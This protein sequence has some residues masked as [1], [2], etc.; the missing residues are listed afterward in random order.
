MA[1][2][3]RCGTQLAEGT[4]FCT[5]CGAVISN[6]KTDK[7]GEGTSEQYKD[8]RSQPSQNTAQPRIDSIN[9]QTAH[10]MP[11]NSSGAERT[12]SPP[13]KETR[14]EPLSVGAF[15]GIAFLM[16]IPIVNIIL[17]IVWACGGAKNPNTRNYARASLIM[18]VVYI[19]LSIIL[20]MLIVNYISRFGMDLLN[21]LLPLLS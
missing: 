10:N 6:V 21:G 3:T 1:F 2:C 4:K 8:V 19:I 16:M 11:P 7:S 9:P 12:I 14:Y 20:G 5:L 18:M 13:V 15:I 17:L